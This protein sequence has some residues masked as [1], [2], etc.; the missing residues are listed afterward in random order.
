MDPS[1]QCVTECNEAWTDLDNFICHACTE[2]LA[3]CI[4]CL[5]SEICMACN[6]DYWSKTEKKCLAVCPTGYM[7]NPNTHTCI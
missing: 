2:T 5:N 6:D 7:G 1:G 4:D 3:N